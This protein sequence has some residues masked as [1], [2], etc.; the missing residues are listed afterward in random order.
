MFAGTEVTARIGLLVPPPN[1]VMESEL[2]RSLPHD[3]TLHTS[4][5]TRSTSAVT[6]DS[7]TEMVVQAPRVAMSLTMTMP[8][9]ILF[10]CTSGSFIHGLGWDAEVA[11]R[12]EEAAGVP[13][14]TTTTAVVRCLRSIGARRIALA[15]PYTTEINE[16]EATFFAAHGFEVCA[17]EGLEIL[18]SERIGRVPLQ[19]TYELGRRVDRPEAD[20]LFISCTN[21]RTLE[22]IEPLERAL[23]KPVLSS[24]MASLWH[25][26]DRLGLAS[27]FRFGGSRLPEWQH[28]AV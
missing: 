12:I 18:E 2:Y 17:L 26:L 13:T 16:R 4:H 22:A 14:A 20:A 10:G 7:L 3:I 5:M 6:V 23:G 21:L 11:R 24:N 27:R 8:D 25:V 1:V 9:V 28:L 19:T 15:T